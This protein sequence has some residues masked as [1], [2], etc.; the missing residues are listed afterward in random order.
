MAEFSAIRGLQPNDPPG[1]IKDLVSGEER[2]VILVG[3]MPSLPRVFTLL[4]TGGEAPFHGFPLH[5][6]IALDPAGELWREVWRI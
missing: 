5:G 6:V 3:H 2:E 1:W 4:V